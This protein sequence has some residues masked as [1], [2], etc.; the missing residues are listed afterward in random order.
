MLTEMILTGANHLKNNSDKIDALNVFPVPD[1]DTGT[2]MNLSMISG[3]EEVKNVNSANISEVAQAFSKVL[4]MVSRG[5][6]GVILSQI[7]REFE[8]VLDNKKKV[9]T[10][11]YT[12]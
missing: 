4:L 2:N 7:I 8:S 3:I 5:N 10:T 11:E 6:T 1:G 9:T 12:E